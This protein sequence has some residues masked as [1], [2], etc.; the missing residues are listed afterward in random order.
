MPEARARGYA[1][2][3]GELGFTAK[4]QYPRDFTAATFLRGW[5]DYDIHGVLR[6][7]CLPSAVLKLTKVCTKP[8]SI[9][10]YRAVAASLGGAYR[11]LDASTPIV[12]VLI[13]RLLM[14]QG[15]TLATKPV[16]ENELY[17]V[18]LFH[19]VEMVREQMLLK[20]IERYGLSPDEV[21]EAED[22]ILRSPIPGAI[23]HRV[24]NVLREVDY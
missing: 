4:V 3:Q 10:G 18:R 23:S 2:I 21:C 7:T 11:G 14:M 16:L 20:I 8:S 6:W 15:E 12:G 17:K 9:G 22:M 5:W 1:A 13:Q 19:R 24:F